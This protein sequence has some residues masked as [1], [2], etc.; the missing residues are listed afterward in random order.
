MKLPNK[1]DTASTGLGLLG[2]LA[3]SQWPMLRSPI[4]YWRVINIV[5][6]AL[7]AIVSAVGFA[8]GDLW[9]AVTAG[10]CAIVFGLEAAG[11]PTLGRTA[12]AAARCS[13]LASG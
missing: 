13:S 5:L 6:A 1:E 11:V 4:V 10:V 8:S 7:A 9:Q 2:S 12:R 3:Y